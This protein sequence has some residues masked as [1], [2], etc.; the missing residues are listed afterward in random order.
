MSSGTDYKGGVPEIFIS[1]QLNAVNQHAPIIGGEWVGVL[2]AAEYLN[3]FMQKNP[4]DEAPVCETDVP[5]VC[6]A[7]RI[8]NI[9]PGQ[10]NN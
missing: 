9:S 7:K 2:F 4:D 10:T 1:S 6:H 3:V 5:V 8:R